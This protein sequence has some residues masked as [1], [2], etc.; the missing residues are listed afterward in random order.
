MTDWRFTHP[1]RLSPGQVSTTDIEQFGRRLRAGEPVD[2]ADLDRYESACRQIETKG[3]AGATA[4]QAAAR[5]LR[6][7]AEL[8][9]KPVT[10]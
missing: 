8:R 1:R 10:T 4:K 2:E 6:Y 7:I 9:Q 3:T 5:V